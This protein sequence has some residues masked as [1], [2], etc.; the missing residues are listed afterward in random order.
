VVISSVVLSVH[1]GC[2]L[3][4]ILIEETRNIKDKPFV[5]MGRSLGLPEIKV[6]Q[7]YILP[8]ALLPWGAQL[9]NVAASLVAGSIIIEVVFS[10]PGLGRLI[11]QSVLENDLPM[12]RGIVLV[13]SVSF[14]ILDF[15]VELIYSISFPGM[16]DTDTS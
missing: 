3:S 11:L 14:I 2:T 1:P 7:H 6:F 5:L 15:I 12:M 8:K 4:Q 16:E 9:S 10:L 13:S